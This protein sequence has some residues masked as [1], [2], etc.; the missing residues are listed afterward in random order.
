MDYGI[1]SHQARAYTVAT[2]VFEGPL[3]LLLH[4][5]ERAELDIT[6]LALAQVTGQYL[7]HIRSM[8]DMPVEEVSAF[9][10]IAAR[11]VQIKSEALLPR[12]PVREEGEEDLGEALA[13][14]LIL[15]KKFKAA[16]Q[17]L[18]QRESSGLR[19][20]LR[21]AAPPK[22][23]GVLD[24]SGIGLSD[25]LEAGR[26]VF[27]LGIPLQPLAQVIAPPRIT[28]REKI[29][30]LIG[31]LRRLPNLTFHKLLSARL[32]RLEIVVT[33]LALLELIKRRVVDVQ[34]GSLFGEIEIAAAG[35]LDDNEDFELEFGE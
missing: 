31:A 8:Q 2:P 28:I 18:V 15:Y 32:G 3:D 19:T 9:L 30:S 27:K 29:G 34:Q 20:Y 22:A 1:A 23:E 14:Q 25:L 6:R 4:L 24:L 7:E 11:L 5:I 17:V 26:V 21:L 35:P 12:P 13:R 16:S 33:F 10:V